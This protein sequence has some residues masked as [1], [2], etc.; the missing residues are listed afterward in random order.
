M[1][2][3]PMLL[4]QRIEYVFI[5]AIFT[6]TDSCAGR[7]EDARHITLPD[8]FT[9]PYPSSGIVGPCNFTPLYVVRNSG[10]VAGKSERVQFQAVVRAKN[11]L[12][13]PVGSL[14]LHF[15]TTENYGTPNFPPDVTLG[16]AA[17]WFKL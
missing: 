5:R 4:H 3:L 9:L 15:Y 14:A 11:W 1:V 13:C 16:K 12:V 6:F 2:A 10:K 17:R 7:G 8:L